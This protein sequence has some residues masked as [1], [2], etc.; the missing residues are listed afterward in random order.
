MQVLRFGYVP[1]AG[2]NRT[3]AEGGAAQVKRGYGDG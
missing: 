3:G 2:T 1:L